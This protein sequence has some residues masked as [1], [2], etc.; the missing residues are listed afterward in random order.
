[1]LNTSLARPLRPMLAALTLLL[2]ACV[3]V[4]SSSPLPPVAPPAIPQLPE[5]ARQPAPPEICSPTCSDGLT[6]LRVS[7][8]GMPIKLGSPDSSAS[9]PTGR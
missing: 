2:S 4:P 9:A 5:A 8:Q 3:S 7:L 1:M 6:R